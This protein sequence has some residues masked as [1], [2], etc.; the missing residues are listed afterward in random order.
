[1]RVE[2][3]LEK[4]NKGLEN[5]RTDSPARGAEGDIARSKDIQISREITTHRDNYETRHTRE[6]GVDYVP[7]MQAARSLTTRDIGVDFTLVMQAV[8]SLTIEVQ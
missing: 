6:I 1:M 4:S 7:V 8:K 2:N 3:R 5:F